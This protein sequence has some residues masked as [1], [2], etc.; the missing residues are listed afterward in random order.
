MSH[1]LTLS[2]PTDLFADIEN[3]MKNAHLSHPEKAVMELIQYA[4]Q[5]PPYFRAYDWEKA[6]EEADKLI[7]S[8]QVKTFNNVEDFLEDL[9]S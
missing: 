1:Q 9:E 6:E 7:A 2:L 3:Y 5:M 8:G 4:L